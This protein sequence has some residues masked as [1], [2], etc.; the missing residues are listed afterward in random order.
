MEQRKEEHLSLVLTS[1]MK[2]I[3]YREDKPELWNQ[4]L[5]LQGPVRDYLK[6]MGLD[7]TIYE[8]DGFAYLETLETG[9]G[10]SPVPR[11]IIR[12]Q[13]SYPVSLMLALLRRKLTEHDAYSGEVRLILDKDEVTDMLTAFFSVGSNEVK[14]LKRIDSY[15]QK[16]HDLGF[17][18]LFGDKK[19]KIEVKRILKAFVDAQWLS[20]LDARL[21]EY[22]NYG[23]NHE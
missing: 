5:N 18:R 11:L 13:L 3:V 10:E 21:E 16:I 14:Y 20:D 19:D 1:L 12:R 15:L 23:E 9:E 7:V 6:V 8:T 4:L 22:R 17:I 2:G